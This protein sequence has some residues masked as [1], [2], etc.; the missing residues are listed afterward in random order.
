MG[1][2]VCVSTNGEKLQ[3]KLISDIIKKPSLHSPAKLNRK[4]FPKDNSALFILKKPKE[5]LYQHS[6][7]FYTAYPNYDECDRGTIN[8]NREKLTEYLSFDSKQMDMIE[9][10]EVLHLPEELTESKIRS[11]AQ[12]LQY[13]NEDQEAHQL[14]SSLVRV[15]F[16]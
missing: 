3:S 13:N 16:C 15:N 4:T 12:A 9:P 14:K 1:N 2:C 10:D 11:Q 5:T 7:S 8:S 6:E